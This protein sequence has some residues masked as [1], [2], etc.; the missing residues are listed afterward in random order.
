MF[1]SRGFRPFFLL[2]VFWAVLALVLWLFILSG[3]LIAESLQIVTVLWHGRAMI[4][5]YG[6]AV[7]CGFLLTAASNWSGLPTLQGRPL[8]LIV[9]AWLLSRIG[10]WLGSSTGWILA[11]LGDVIFWFGFIIGLSRPLL[12]TKDSRNFWTFIPKLVLFGLAAVGFDLGVLLPS[13]A[14]WQPTLLLLGLLMMVAIIIAMGIRV[15]PFFISRAL[16][17]EAPPHSFGAEE[18]IDLIAMTGFVFSLVFW[19]DNPAVTIFAVTAVVVNGRRLWRW[20]D[21][22]IWQKPML[23][24]LFL[25]FA[26]LLLGILLLGFSAI[27]WVPYYPA[28]HALAYGGAGLMTTG[29]M[30]RVSLGHTGRSVLQ[31]PPLATAAFV[32]LVV[33]TGVRVAGPWL[34][35]GYTQLYILMAGLLWIL[36]M[37]L[38][39][40]LLLPILL[41]PQI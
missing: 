30:I 10:P 28:L 11:L 25:G 37:A 6:S 14:S 26:A 1:L 13:I 34:D 24:I 41:R 32:L 19:P 36:A 35:A 15:I 21:P 23:W 7:V 2:A 9:V 20:H 33:G 5:A 39:L 16:Q 8:L 29:M 38:L 3:S 22:V 40:L 27:D 12:A 17:R 18:V 31:A 4:F